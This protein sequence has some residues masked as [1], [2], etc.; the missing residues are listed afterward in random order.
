MPVRAYEWQSTNFE[1]VTTGCALNDLRMPMKRE[2][3]KEVIFIWLKFLD[4]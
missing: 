1:I 3:K 2:A 4:L